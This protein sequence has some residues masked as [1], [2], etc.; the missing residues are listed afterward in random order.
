VQHCIAVLR[1]G[2]SAASA[3]QQ[4]KQ[5]RDDNEN[6]TISI[7]VRAISTAQLGKKLVKLRNR[8][9][10]LELDLQHQIPNNDVLDDCNSAYREVFDMDDNGM[11]VI[12]LFVVKH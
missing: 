12:T 3:L 7:D 9:A 1:S 11:L 2:K 6:K 8:L 4:A 10:P 5:L